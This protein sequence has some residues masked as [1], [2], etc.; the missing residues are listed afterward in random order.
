[1][2][3]ESSRQLDSSS[4]SHKLFPLLGAIGYKE[5]LCHPMTSQNAFMKMTTRILCPIQTHRWPDSYWA[6]PLTIEKNTHFSQYGPRAL[7]ELY[8]GCVFGNLLWPGKSLQP[9]QIQHMP[10]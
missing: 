7:T 9:S 4:S 2:T 6:G 5:Y 1:M 3:R 8:I 10:Y